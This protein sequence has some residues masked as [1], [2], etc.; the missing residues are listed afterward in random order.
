MKLDTCVPLYL[1]S[2]VSVYSDSIFVYLSCI[3]VTTNHP[4]AYTLACVKTGC[5]LGHNLQV[6]EK[7]IFNRMSP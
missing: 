7:V 1:E 3:H 6:C 4:Y 5:F 2:Y